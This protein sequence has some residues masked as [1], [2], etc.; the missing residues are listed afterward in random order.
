MLHS[1]II[2]GCNVVRLRR[3]GLDSV[4]VLG[5]PGGGGGCPCRADA[6]MKP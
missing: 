4:D 3:A 1:F 2:P 6:E 5:A